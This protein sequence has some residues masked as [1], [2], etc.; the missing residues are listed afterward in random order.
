MEIEQKIINTMRKL[1]LDEIAEANS[2]HPGVALGLAPALFAVYK[3]ANIYP[4][5]ANWFNRDRIVLSGGHASS[6]LYATLFLFG[7]D[8]SLEDLKEFRTLGSLTPGHPEVNV[9]SGV[10]AS[11]GAL[12][13]GIA[14]GVGMCLAEK[15]IASLYNKKDAKICD[16]Y[17]FVF[18]GDGDLMEGISY[19]ALS[20]AGTFN[21]N[22]LIVLYDSND[23]TMTDSLSVT[24]AENTKQRFE[25]MGFDVITVLKGNDYKEIEKAIKKAKTKSKPT[26]IICKTTIGFGSKLANS[27]K[28]HGK[29][30]TKEE[31][32][33]I[34][35]NFGMSSV[36]FDV[37]QDVKEYC[38]QLSNKNAQ[39]YENWQKIKEEY[40]QKYP[41]EFEELFSDN[42]KRLEKALNKISF[43]KPISTREASGE[44]LNTLANTLNNFFGGGADVAKS[45]MAYLNDKG[46]F[47]KHNPCG[48]NIPFGVREHAMG[49][50]CNGI[51][52]HGGLRTFASTFLIF[53]DYMR[54]AIRQSA[55]MDLSV[56]YLFSHDSI[57]IGQDGPSH[58]PIEQVASLRLIPN[59][60]VI[61]PADANETVSAYKIAIDNPA[62]TALIL[63]RQTLPILKGSGDDALFGAYVI[64]KEK[65]K[66]QAILL[67]SGSE[68]SLCVQAQEEL[69][70]EDIDVRVVSV[71][72][73][74]LFLKQTAKYQNSVLPKRCEKILAV[75]YGCGETFFKFIG[76]TGKVMRINSFGESGKG[77]EIADLFG[78]NVENIVKNVKKM[79]K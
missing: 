57:M 58:Q 29:P 1:A 77:Q 4:K 71:P 65:K 49:G 46:D 68:V 45:T 14:Q 67:A 18:C 22:K 37:S 47:S 64:S 42:V 36:P 6:V 12:G 48:Q 39:N 51:C 72:C 28:C 30:F 60:A 63:S 10:D 16:H 75:D 31:V 41:N 70:K 24:S 53:C 76:K 56:L 25:A 27:A 40:K 13:Q 3:N 43:K 23:I 32:A 54:Y 79:I 20:L 11:T 34:C 78:I 33:E 8:L 50:I 2:G 9:T 44:I 35:Q 26:L 61:R 73:A 7:Y 15:H 52:L 19:E 21:L 38:A 62:P 17:T 59:L 5:D 55:L 66:M 74:E 69:L